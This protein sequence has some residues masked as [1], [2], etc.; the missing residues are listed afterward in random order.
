[1]KL[2]KA[3]MVAW[4]A[5]IGTLLVGSVVVLLLDKPEWRTTVGILSI[6][7]GFLAFVY[8]RRSVR[9]RVREK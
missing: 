3:L 8:V 2:G 9:R 5:W 7:I 4:G 6:V 1:M